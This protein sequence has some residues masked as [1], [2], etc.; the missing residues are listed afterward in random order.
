MRSCPY[1]LIFLPVSIKGMGEVNA[2]RGDEGQ[3]LIYAKKR[4]VDLSSSD[5][6][7][8]TPS[9]CVRDSD[10]SHYTTSD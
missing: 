8:R 3:K 5:A 9:C 1:C 6:G 10:V 7:N 4:N 2:A